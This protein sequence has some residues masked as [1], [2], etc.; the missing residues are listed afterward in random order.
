M[1]LVSAPCAVHVEQ[2]G[3]LR[4]T[5]RPPCLEF[6]YYHLVATTNI[7]MF[8]LVKAVDLREE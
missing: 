6:V 3:R 5:V 1:W 2:G 4:F 7:G 8:D